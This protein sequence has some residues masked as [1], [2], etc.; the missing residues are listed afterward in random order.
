MKAVI[1]F[2]VIVIG[3]STALAQES[4][5]QS[6]AQAYFTDTELITQ[7]GQKVRFYT[8]VLKNKVVVINCFF[9]TCQGSCLPMGRNVV[10]LQ[11]MLDPAVARDVVFVSISVDPAIDTPER[12]KSYATK[13]GAKPGW[14]LLTGTKENVDLI[15]KKLGQYVEDKTAHNNI[16]IIGNDRTGLW[17]KAFGLAKA[18]EL[19]K[20][21][22]S[23]A[24]D[25]AATTN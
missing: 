4:S 15:H 23:V 20:V 5:K 8:D 6:F 21:I 9:A 24:N 11:E 16:F 10:R 22:E 12:L 14:L 7:D 19:Y 2:A 1:L 3:G 25:K 17:K 13:M 18:E